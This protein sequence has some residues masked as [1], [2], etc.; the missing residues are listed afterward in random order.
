VSELDPATR[1]E[2]AAAALALD[3][4]A[5]GGAIIRAPRSDLAEAFVARLRALLPEQAPHRRLPLAIPDDRLLGGLDLAMTL[6]QGRPVADRGLLAALDGGLLIVPGA[7]RIGATLAARLTQVLDLGIVAQRVRADDAPDHHAA[8]VM[9]IAIDEAEADEDP[10]HGALTDRCAFHLT[11]DARPLPALFTREDIAAAATLF[12]QVDATG[13]ARS[14]S[15]DDDTQVRA[16][17]RT[18]IHTAELYGISSLR[19][20]RAALRTARCL[21]AL[22]GRR[23]TNDADVATAA[24]LVLGPRATRLPAPPPD[25]NAEQ[26]PP[27]PPPPDNSQN[28]DDSADRDDQD[29]REL[30]DR[31]IEAIAAALP[32]GLTMD[33]PSRAPKSGRA[34]GRSGADRSSGMRGRQVGTRR[35][36]PRHGGRL[37]LVETLR[38]A[39]PW[40][41]LRRRQTVVSAHPRVLVR[42]DDFRIR[43]LY[44]PAG[45]TA[46]FVVDASGSSAVNR[47][48]EAKGAVELLLAESYA[49][50]DEVALIAFRGTQADIL[51]PPT[52]AIAA[53]KRAL[54]A[55]P[56]GGGTPLAAA[57]DRA[58]E[59]TLR[60]RREGNDTVVVFL[61]DA[62]ANV[63]RDGSGGRDR[64]MQDALQ[65][66]RV[67]RSLEGQVLFIDTSPRPSPQA[68][69][70]AMAMGARYIALPRTDARSI[71]AAV[72]AARA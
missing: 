12:P 15:A 33:A 55:L 24:A 1:A 31:I 71:H 27:P 66:A 29:V 18:L 63:A 72:T 57:I 6:A 42:P 47:M 35:G 21:A 25:P 3:G 32:V 58:V 22:D 23:L 45:T 34:A 43:R 2:L 38:T 14:D 64:A 41:P 11:L 54:A 70:V 40:Q 16:R 60:A 56:G 9:I 37:D 10:V 69:D 49:R 53:A 17:V 13:D 20:V 61:T 59:L 51:L 28:R 65:S 7:E 19:A 4:F 50:R 30:E 52:R 8:R 68:Q 48:A 44:E 62:R 26:E 46:I 5:L 36:D 67:L 39:A